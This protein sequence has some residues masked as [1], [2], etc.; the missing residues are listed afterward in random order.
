MEPREYF[1]AVAKELACIRIPNN[2]HNED[3]VIDFIWDLW[4]RNVAPEIA[5]EFVINKFGVGK[6]KRPN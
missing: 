5:A 3:E 1:T 4:R 2:L 6:E